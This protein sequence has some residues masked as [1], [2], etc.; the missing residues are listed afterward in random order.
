MNKG[1]KWAKTK[2]SASDLLLY[3]AVEVYRVHLLS[4]NKDWLRF[5]GFLLSD[6]AVNSCKTSLVRSVIPLFAG[7]GYPMTV[8]RR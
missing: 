4:I 5:I 6:A 2:R 7:I 8:H 1:E 3:P